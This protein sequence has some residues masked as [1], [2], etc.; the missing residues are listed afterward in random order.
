MDVGRELQSNNLLEAA[1]KLYKKALSL[2]DSDQLYAYGKDVVNPYVSILIDHHNYEEALHV[3]E[4]ELV[5]AQELAR[6]HYIH[7]VALC[8]GVVTFLSMPEKVDSKVQ[9]VISFVPSFLTSN[10]YQAFTDML[11]AYYNL[12]YEEFSNASRRAVF[13]NLEVPVISP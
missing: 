13:N 11:N 8:I 1:V 6:D 10:E 3:Y 9:E 12:R 7:K 5:F 2:V 4:K